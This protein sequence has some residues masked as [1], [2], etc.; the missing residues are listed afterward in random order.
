MLVADP[1]M[2]V[3]LATLR[4][5]GIKVS[6][7]DFGTGYS[8]LAYLKDMS[9]DSLKVPREF[10]SEISTSSR[11][12]AVVD[13]IVSVGH[14]LGLSVVAEGVETIEQRRL[15]HNLGVTP[16]G[17][18]ESR[19]RN[20][21]VSRDVGSLEAKILAET[22]G[23][24]RSDVCWWLLAEH[25]R[26]TVARPLIRESKFECL[27]RARL[28]SAYDGAVHSALVRPTC[29]NTSGFL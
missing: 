18:P 13:A 11:S 2:F 28:W 19:L 22:D 20:N 21:P 25:P 14:A 12:L 15:L 17:C 1:A 3:A 27:P 4:E 26:V 16:D 29:P 23:D 24:V 7:D 10:V 6:I 8:S 5:G 9:A